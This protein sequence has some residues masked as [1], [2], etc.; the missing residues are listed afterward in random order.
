M[1]NMSN[2]VPM[3]KKK[4]MLNMLNMW[5]RVPHGSGKKSPEM[6]NM[7]NMLTR[8]PINSTRKPGTVKYVEYGKSGR[9]YILVSPTR[10]G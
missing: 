6:L 8:V 9:A 5:N 7:L 3:D 10:A 2:R 1:L 4:E